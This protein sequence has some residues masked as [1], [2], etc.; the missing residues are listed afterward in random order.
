MGTPASFFPGLPT[1]QGAAKI[2]ELITV[3]FPGE[4]EKTL[5][6]WPLSLYK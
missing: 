3:S 4:A 2:S 5:K 6:T 1:P